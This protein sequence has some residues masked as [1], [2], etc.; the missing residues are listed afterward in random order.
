MSESPRRA[1]AEIR[2]DVEYLKTTRPHL[3]IPCYGGQLTELTFMSFMRWADT[4]RQ[5]GIHWTVD[6]TT[7]QALI[8]R[9][10]NTLVAKFLRTPRSTHLMFVDADIGWEP[11]H[12]LALLCARKDVVGGLY[13]LKILP[14]RWAIEDIPGKS[15]E[16]DGNLVEVARAATGFLLIK[17]EVFEQLDAH[18]A[19]RPFA[20]DI[21]LPTDLEPNLRTYFDTSV[22][23]GRYYSE[24]W[25]FCANWRDLGGKVFVDK[26]VVLRHA[27]NYV[28]D[29]AT[30]EKLYRDLKAMFEPGDA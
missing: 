14:V 13:P 23:E 11:W 12:L 3:C 1:Q 9:A 25:T 5:L 27:G 28:F 18:P 2:V 4:C 20:N 24:G 30:H 19:V 8:S 16:P 15:A 6:T 17:R 21:G 10:R 29:F 7:N 22:R 26:R